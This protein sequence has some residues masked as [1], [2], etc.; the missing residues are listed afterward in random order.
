MEFLYEWTKNLSFYMIIVTV[1]LQILPSEEYKGYVRFFIGAVLV[2]MLT[3]PIMSLFH[4]K[5]QFEEFYQD[6][7]QMKARLEREWSSD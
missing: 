1:I 5:G 4:M 2:L 3:Q 7:R 6:A